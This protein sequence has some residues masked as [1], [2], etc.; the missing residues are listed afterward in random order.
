MSQRLTNIRARRVSLVDRAAVRDPHN[1]SQ[2]RRF[3]LFK[4]ESAATAN[5]GD[6]DVS[7][8]NKEDLDPAVRELVEKSEKEAADAK[9]ALEKREEDLKKAEEERDAAIAK[10]GT[11]TGD[12]E[13]DD[14][15]DKKL[16]KADLEKLPEAVQTVLAKADE[17]AQKAEERIKKAEEKAD[18]ASDLAKAETKR[19][20]EGEFIAK[21]D[22]GELRGI[23][24]TPDE[25]GK[26]LYTLAKAE[27]E[28][29]AVLEKSVLLP[30]AAQ[31]RTSDLLKEQGRGG[32]GPPPESAL[33]KMNEKVTELRKADS[34]LTRSQALEKARKENPDIERAVSA[35]MRGV[36]AGTA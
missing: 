9:A 6:D 16:S 4:A 34:S 3:V 7:T 27:P 35:E 11:S 19:R 15:D 12:E 30:A 1:P 25:I 28:A 23:P 22:T 13:D 32:E 5:E 18:S 8:I 36:P 24:G 20:E 21:A 10:A 17:R 33:A 29:Y 2:P 31:I 14:K 26:A